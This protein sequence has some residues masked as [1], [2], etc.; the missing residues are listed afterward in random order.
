MSRELQRPTADYFYYMADDE[1]MK[2]EFVIYSSNFNECSW[3][4]QSMLFFKSS[5]TSNTGFDWLANT[6]FPTTGLSCKVEIKTEGGSEN[7]INNFNDHSEIDPIN[8]VHGHITKM[9]D[10]SRYM[11]QINSRI[12][13]LQVYSPYFV[14]KEIYDFYKFII[15]E[16]FKLFENTTFINENKNLI[17]EK[18]ND[19]SSRFFYKLLSCIL[20]YFSCEE[21]LKISYSLSDN[22]EGLWG[23]EFCGVSFIDLCR[24]RWGQLPDKIIKTK[25]QDFTKDYLNVEESYD[26]V[27]SKDANI[28]FTVFFKYL[29]D[30]NL[31]L[32][33]HSISD[34]MRNTNEIHISNKY[35]SILLRLPKL[36]ETFLKPPSPISKIDISSTKPKTTRQKRESVKKRGIKP[37]TSEHKIEGSKKERQDLISSRRVTR[38]NIKQYRGGYRKSRKQRKTKKNKKN[39]H[40]K[41]K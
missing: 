2:R 5:G 38:S 36:K 22:N 26:F 3:P 15:D 12:V 7:K 11:K 29:E 4:K 34:F 25:S 23:W 13:K 24:K 14:F 18:Y 21:Q 1:R 35:Y 40:K 30:N 31:F 37:T 27:V 41:K 32:K 39:Y 17:L 28:D 10:Y 8:H 19:P 9:S 16:F 6:Y 20:N 33:E